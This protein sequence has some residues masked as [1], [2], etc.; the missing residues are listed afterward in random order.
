MML[1]RFLEPCFRHAK[2]NMSAHTKTDMGGVSTTQVH[3]RSGVHVGIEQIYCDYWNWWNLASLTAH[4]HSF[5]L[6]CSGTDA[7]CLDA[8]PYNAG[9]RQENT[10]SCSFMSDG[11]ALH[12]GFDASTHACI[13]S[14]CSSTRITRVIKNAESLFWHVSVNSGPLYPKSPRHSNRP[15]LEQKYQAQLQCPYRTT[16]TDWWPCGVAGISGRHSWRVLDCTRNH[17]KVRKSKSQMI[18]M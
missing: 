18:Q 6:A 3:W 10:P 4:F 11:S 7:R 12:I 13:K 16:C 1:T 9:S 14:G 8:S 15:R 2:W 17:S 5:P